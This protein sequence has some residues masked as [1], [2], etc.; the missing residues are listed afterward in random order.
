MKQKQQLPFS[1]ERIQHEF[2]IS[3]EAVRACGFTPEELQTIY[4]DYVR[5]YP[6]LE[7]LQR[8]FISR[9]MLSAEGV[10]FHSYGG[11]VKAPDHLI[12]KIIRKRNNR[13]RKYAQMRVDDYYKYITD[14]IGCRI[15]LVYKEDWREVHQ[16]LNRVFDND[17]ANYIDGN[18]RAAS[19][20]T[21]DNSGFMAERPCVFIRAGD[22]ERLYRGVPDI[23]IDRKGYYRS[24]HYLLRFHEYYL[25]LQV[26]SLFEEAWSEVDHDLL[27]P[28]YK[29][30]KMLVNFS[31]LLNRTA[32]LGDEMSS[33]FKEYV[34]NG[35][36]EK[37]GS[38]L[39]TPGGTADDHD[40]P[41]EEDS[42]R[43]MIDLLTQSHKNQH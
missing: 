21:G 4:E 19:Y 30:N 18:N 2:N 25:E 39:D 22:D 41:V 38:L 35:S 8:E 42:T 31:R 6:R 3:D 13:N 36:F 16:Y 37:S 10:H 14:L 20:Q 11:R 43:V 32:G 26:R 34:F 24:A 23:R 27:Y 9:Y 15:L 7:Q 28:L 12:E 29:G 1:L 17:P 5:R 40:T 33:Y